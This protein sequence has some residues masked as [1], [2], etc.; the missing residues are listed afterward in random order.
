MVLRPGA[1]V[2][3]CNRQG[4]HAAGI[5]TPLTVAGNSPAA[6]RETVPLCN[7][8]VQPGRRYTGRALS[9]AAYE[10][11]MGLSDPSVGTAI[12]GSR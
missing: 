4:R 8:L 12:G 10:V 9:S 2:L 5:G 6:P 7:D 3:I 1:Y 11:V